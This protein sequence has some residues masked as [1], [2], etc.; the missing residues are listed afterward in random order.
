[1]TFKHT[2]MN[3]KSRQPDFL[4]VGLQEQ[5]IAELMQRYPKLTRTE[6]ADIVSAKGPMRHHVE[7]ELARLSD[8]KR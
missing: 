2:T 3:D 6:I 5:E 1:V 8:A 7:Q 4:R